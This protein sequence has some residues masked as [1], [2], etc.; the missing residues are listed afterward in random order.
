M[1]FGGGK[2]IFETVQMM[3]DFQNRKTKNFNCIL[4]I[5]KAKFFRW[6]QKLPDLI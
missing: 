5:L 4:S 1:I 3:L 6:F 2:T